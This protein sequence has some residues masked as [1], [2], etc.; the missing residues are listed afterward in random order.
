MELGKSYGLVHLLEVMTRADINS[1]DAG[2]FV[3][4]GADGKGHGI[5]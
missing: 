1:L 5:G 3:E 2:L 4:N